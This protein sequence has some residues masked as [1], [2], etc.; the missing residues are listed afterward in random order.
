[1]SKKKQM[2]IGALVHANGSHA[3][4]WL[5]DEARPH[6]STDIDHYREMAQL[7]ERGKLDFFFIADTPAARTENLRAWSRSPLFMNVLEPLTL[8]SAI[9]GATSHI[10]LGATASTSFYEPYNIARL[11]A[12]LDHISHGRAAWNVVTSANDYAARNF[13]LDRLPPHADRYAKAKEFVDVVEALWDSWEDGAFVYDKAACQS[14]IPEKQHLVDHKGTYFTVHGALNLER[15]PQGRPVIIQAGASDTGRDFAAEYAEVVFGSSGNLDNAVAFYR[16]LKDRMGKFGRRPDDLKIAS[17][18]S[19]V[20]GETEQEARDKLERWQELVHP[21]VGVLRLGQDLETDLSD[22]PLDEPVPVSRIPATS[23]LHKAYFDEI[24]GLIRQGLT[25]R[26]IARRFNR[27]KATFCGTVTQVADHME[28]W[29]EVGACDGFM[30]SFAALPSTMSDF[31]TKVVPELQRR[32]VF[33]EDYTGRTLRDHLGLSRPE[34]RHVAAGAAPLA[35]R[36]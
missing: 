28:H 22:L 15:P 31:V 35:K 19:V 3:A 26:E 10:G 30:I 1:M 13:G 16:D 9:A 14:F 17:G 11:F 24:A 27:A 36:A 18:I 6:A 5:M 2:V 29:I 21:D 12:S 34:N 32:G 20:L 25:L 23:N 8:L 33:R 4:S 7:A